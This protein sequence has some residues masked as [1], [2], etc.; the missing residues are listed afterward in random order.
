M[1]TGTG[2]S[3]INTCALLA[4]G[5]DMTAVGSA[6]TLESWL[7]LPVAGQIPMGV[8]SS[9]LI[10]GMRFYS[11]AS[12]NPP[13]NGGWSMRL[14]MG[15][16]GSR[17]PYAG[18]GSGITASG[19]PPF[20]ATGWQLCRW[21]VRTGPSNTLQFVFSAAG[22]PRATV[23]IAGNLG[24]DPITMIRIAPSRADANTAELGRPP[25]AKTMFEA[26]QISSA[27]TG[28]LPALYPNFKPTA[29]LDTSLNNLNVIPFTGDP[30]DSANLLQEVIQ[31]EYG[32]GFFDE[33]GDY[34]FLNRNAPNRA[35][36]NTSAK[37]IR[38]NTR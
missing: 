38:S 28:N 14:E 16:L 33:Y 13:W 5:V 19:V 15:M 32:I 23:T 25:G 9:D 1:V 34:Y 20:G 36:F 3:A 6:L 24:P 12:A 22:T 21:T 8:S 31:A 29:W 18:D 11:N 10:W 27:A 30:V 4:S 26:V 2:I 7:Y 35:P 17:T 37:T